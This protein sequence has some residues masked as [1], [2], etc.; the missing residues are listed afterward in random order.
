MFKKT[1]IIAAALLCTVAHAQQDPKA[2]AA[3]LARDFGYAMTIQGRCPGHTRELY[4]ERAIRK[5]II[6]AIVRKTHMNLATIQPNLEAGMNKANAVKKPTAKDCSDADEQMALL[7]P[8]A[9]E[10]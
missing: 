2:Q 10:S 1:L 7:K 3:E 8:Q 6:M 4:E 9:S 5:E